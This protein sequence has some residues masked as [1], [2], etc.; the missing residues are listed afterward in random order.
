MDV[1]KSI[2]EGTE[3]RI[4]ELE[5]IDFDELYKHNLIPGAISKNYT[6]RCTY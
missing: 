6:K 3:E 2:I 4:S 5:E 1:L